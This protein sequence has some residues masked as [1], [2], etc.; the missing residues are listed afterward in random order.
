MHQ[1]L[2]HLNYEDLCRLDFREKKALCEYCVMA[3]HTRTPY[4][5]ILTNRSSR[6]NELLHSDLWG[7]ASQSGSE[8][9][10]YYINI[11]D[12]FTRRVVTLPIQYKFEAA[13]IIKIVLTNFN[14][15]KG[16]WP[17][18]FLSD[19]GGEFISDELRSFLQQK[20]VATDLTTTNSP[21]SNGVSERMNRTLVEKARAMMNWAKLPKTFWHQAIT[22][23]AYLRNRSPRC[24]NNANSPHE[25]WT[26]KKQDLT[27][28]RVFGCVAYAHNKPTDKLDSKSKKGIF[29]GYGKTFNHYKIFFPDTKQF[30]VSRD[31]MFDE[32]LP[33]GTIP[34]HKSSEIETIDINELWDS[35]SPESSAF[36]SPP[37]SSPDELPTSPSIVTQKKARESIST[38]LLLQSALSQNSDDPAPSSRE[39]DSVVTNHET[40]GNQLNT[41]EHQPSTK[42]FVPAASIPSNLPNSH[43][44]TSRPPKILVPAASVPSSVPSFPRPKD[45][46][47]RRQTPLPSTIPSLSNMEVR[48]S[49]RSN[50]GNKYEETI[51]KA[52]LTRE[53]RNVVEALEHPAWK[54]GVLEEYNSIVDNGTFL[55]QKIKILL[56][57]NGFLNLRP[58]KKERSFA[59]KL[60]WLLKGFHRSKTKIIRRPLPL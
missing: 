14:N 24:S 15:Q 29:M 31:V 47:S 53:P 45:Q 4:R 49:S 58:M 13:N 27:N 25:I 20:G 52:L 5:S 21:Q 60:V 40:G 46:S 37:D 19:K 30:I 23:A 56:A 17:I 38:W 12:D 48:R 44:P 36:V 50:I 28:L 1:R 34:Q 39:A 41:S 33:G 42:L 10:K 8:G 57:A 9:E 26:G 2:G 7:P 18:H 32:S 59:I 16:T 54:K 51:R 55:D 3:K 6:P 35:L 11:I 22:A 43:Q